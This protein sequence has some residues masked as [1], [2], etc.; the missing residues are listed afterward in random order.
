MQSVLA[1]LIGRICSVYIDD[2]VVWGRTVQKHHANLDQVLT[3]IQEAGLQLKPTKCSF[4]VD[5]IELLGHKITPAGIEPLP[6]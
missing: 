1:G 5:K 3:R 6:S 2:I 4:G